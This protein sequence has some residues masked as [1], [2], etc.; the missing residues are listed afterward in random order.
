MVSNRA[1]KERM[2]YS[3]EQQARIGHLDIVFVIQGKAVVDAGGQSDH[4]AFIHL[5]PYPTLI[6][7]PHVKITTT[8]VQ[9]TYG[10]PKYHVS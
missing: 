5:D 2:L 6:L 9:G 7:S 4:V 8:C 10:R 3:L 1:I